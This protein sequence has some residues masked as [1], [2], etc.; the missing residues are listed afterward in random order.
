[1]PILELPA[2]RRANL[3][4]L[5]FEFVSERMAQS[6]AQP[7]NGLDREFSALIQVHNTYFSGMKSGAR[8]IGDKLAGQIEVLCHKDKGWMDRPPESAVAH[9]V[10][11]P[12]DLLDF[13]QLAEKAYVAAPGYRLRFITMLLDALKQQGKK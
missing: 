6:P 10:E 13:L 11:K 5:F 3:L 1:M 8:T 9:P 7:I 4:Q 2:I 12:A